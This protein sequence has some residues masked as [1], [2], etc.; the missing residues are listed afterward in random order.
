MSLRGRAAPCMIC[1]DLQRLAW[2]GKDLHDLLE[3]LADNKVAVLGLARGREG[4]ERE[5]SIFLSELK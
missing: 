5:R 3:M 1:R 4:T 2:T